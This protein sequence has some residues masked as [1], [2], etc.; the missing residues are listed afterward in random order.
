EK[1]VSIQ[2]APSFDQY[3]ELNE[4]KAQSRKKDT[5]IRKLKARI[6]S[7]SGNMNEDKEQGLIIV[8]LK[9][10]I[11]KHKGK[12]LDDNAVTIHTITLEMLKFD[13]EPL[14]PR[15]LNN[16]T[17]HSDYLMLTRHSMLNANFKL[18]SVK[19][20][21]CILTNNHDLCVLNVINDVN[22]YP[23]SKFVKKTSK[24]KVWKPTGKV[25]TKTGYTWRP[26]GRTFTIVGNACPTITTE[27]PFRKLIALEND[28][29]KHVVTFA[30][31]RKPRKSKTNVPYLDS[32]CSKNMTRDHSQLTNFVNKFLGTVKFKN[33][34]MAKIMG[35]GDYQIRNV[36]ISQVGISHETSVAR[37][38]QQ[39]GVVERRNRMLIEA[40]CTILEPVLHEMTHA[41][42][43]SGLVPN[44]S[45]STPFVPPLR[46]DWN[47]LFQPLFDELSTPPPSVDLP[48]SKVIAP[49]A[50]VVPPE[51]A[52]STGS[53]SST[54]VDQ[55]APV[56]GNSQTSPE[57]QSP[58]I[59]ND[60]EEE[61]HDLDVAHMNNDPFFG[62]LIPKN[63]SESSSS[64][65]I[66]TVVHTAAPNSEHV[67]KWTMDHPLDNIIGELERP[68]STRL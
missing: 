57:T 25:F 55:D 68:V 30:Y 51:P 22:A 49:I 31:S 45:L 24:R 5:V 15:L 10:E 19:C 65:V 26:T 47:I 46:T 58:V 28:A 23:K 16:K 27:V 37:S 62:I 54:I 13:V 61:N 29:P 2:S 52:A 20:N 33:D 11:R 1:S 7:L 59:S 66:P 64:D 44:P 63:D 39:N 60:V 56:P 12:A 32:G 3:F 21:G 36:T 38:P 4:L 35:Y 8:D 40:T 43:S 41:T 50:N 67:T 42:I 34:H 9:D 14:A 17:V 18:I 53:P 6:K 48:A